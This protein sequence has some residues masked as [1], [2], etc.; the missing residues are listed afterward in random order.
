[1]NPG[2]SLEESDVQ[3]KLTRWIDGIPNLKPALLAGEYLDVPESPKRFMLG[4][5][6]TGCGFIELYAVTEADVQ[7]HGDAAKCEFVFKIRTKSGCII[8][9]TVMQGKDAEAA[10]YRLRLRYPNCEILEMEET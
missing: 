5:C 3:K 7:Y 4:F 2:Y 10:K 8:E 1:M 6:C 9:N